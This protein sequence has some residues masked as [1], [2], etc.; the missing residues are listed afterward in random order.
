MES[1]EKMV[2]GKRRLGVTGAI[3]LGLIGLLCLFVVAEFRWDLAE[4]WVGSYLE[5][6]NDRRLRIGAAWESFDRTVHAVGK[7]DTLVGQLRIRASEVE[8]LNNLAQI[9]KLL[10]P[11]GGISV[12]KEQFLSLFQG[13]SPYLWQEWM[14]AKDLLQM[15][16]QRGWARSYL[17]WDGGTLD[18]Y[19]VDRHNGV[20][21]RRSVPGDWLEV[22]GMHRQR[23]AGVLDE[24]G[25]FHRRIYP[26]DRLWQVLE[27]LDEELVE[28]LMSAQG[29]QSGY[30]LV[31]IGLSNL[32]VGG[33]GVIGL[34][35]SLP[36]GTVIER[37]V[38]RDDDLWEFGVLLERGWK[39]EASPGMF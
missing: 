2:F 19:L 27:D 21:Y 4:R 17:W 18:I 35:F 1:L 23:N 12:S 8:S 13:L 14:P 36:E 37:V 5:W 16:Q 38:V 39:R 24:S 33:L 26:A 31:Q 22:A 9:P 10:S 11:R 6:H 15:T 32:A 25:E 30:P 7:V 28:Q 34:E 20:L 29:L 3:W